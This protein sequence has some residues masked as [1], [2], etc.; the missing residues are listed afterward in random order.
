MT[1]LNAPAYD[2]RKER[3]NA[4]IFIGI[5]IT[6][7]LAV[8]ICLAG[9]FTGH[10]WFFTDLPAEWRVSHFFTAIEQGDFNQAYAIKMAD[11]DWAQHSDRYKN[12]TFEEFKE[13]W[14]TGSQ[15]GPIRSH[16]VDISKRVGSGSGAS[17]VVKVRVNGLTKQQANPLS[18]CVMLQDKTLVDCPV[19]LSY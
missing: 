6:I 15:Y 18:I 2:Q 7:F 12:Y 16:H 8:V 4:A 9:Y 13:D 17:I 14:T 19:D 5:L 1:L 3:R 10:G 11:P